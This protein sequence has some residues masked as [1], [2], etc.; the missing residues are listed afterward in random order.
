MGRICS[1]SE[2]NHKLNKCQRFSEQKKSLVSNRSSNLI[3]GL[4]KDH[5]KIMSIHSRGHNIGNFFKTKSDKKLNK[6]Y[7]KCIV[8]H[9][10]F[11]FVLHIVGKDHTV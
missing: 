1:T 4:I 9:E 10:G 2:C 6:F 3:Y 8:Y 7:L 5:W 11:H